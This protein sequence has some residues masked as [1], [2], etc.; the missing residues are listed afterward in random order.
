MYSFTHCTLIFQQLPFTATHFFNI[1]IHLFSPSM[2]K[3]SCWLLIHLCTAVV[4]TGL[5][6]VEVTTFVIPN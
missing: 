6:L 5:Y 1:S 2:K 4:T 3:V